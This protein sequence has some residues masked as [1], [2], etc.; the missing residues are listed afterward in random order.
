MKKICPI[1]LLSFFLILLSPS[2][3]GEDDE[4][5][6]E[7]EF[8]SMTGCTF[9]FNGGKNIDCEYSI[10]SVSFTSTKGELVNSSP[11][12]GNMLCSPISGRLL[13]GKVAF[14][15][16]GVCPFTDKAR[17]A[18]DAG[19]IA[20]IIGDSQEGTAPVRMKGTG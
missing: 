7:E 5:D 2:V 1:L 20:L 19:A 11:G 8:V 10:F 3:R 14:S 15:K 16:R 4:F 17:V 12:D 6:D 9:S 13:E 18:Q